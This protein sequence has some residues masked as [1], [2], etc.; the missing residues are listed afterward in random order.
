MIP[1]L[2]L[3]S[4]ATP[5]AAQPVDPV[6][7]EIA[8][9]IPSPAELDALGVVL[10]RVMGA[11][12][13]VEIGGLMDAIDPDGGDSRSRGRDRRTI[14]DLAERDDPYARERMQR[15]VEVATANM[16]DV[17]TDIAI[18]APRL[19]RTFEH[20]GR[21]IEDATRDLPRRDRR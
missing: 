12:M 1:V 10:G 7:A 13:D 3:L 6:D 16:G 18:L 8:R 17:M 15:G 21:D 11:M 14:G 20:V 5:L 19:R 4:F 9:A 2:P